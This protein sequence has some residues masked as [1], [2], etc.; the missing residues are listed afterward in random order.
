[1]DTK[2]L[3]GVKN[4]NAFLVHRLAERDYIWHNKVRL[5]NFGP[6]FREQNVLRQRISRTLLVGARRNLTALRVWS[7]DTYSHNLVN[8]CP[9]VPRYHAAICISPSVMQLNS[10]FLSSAARCTTK[11]SQTTTLSTVNY[12]CIIVG[13]NFQQMSIIFTVQY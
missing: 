9:R 2:I 11:R 7:I 8:F 13:F 10:R 6:L 12:Q 3:K 1:L 4:C 5:V